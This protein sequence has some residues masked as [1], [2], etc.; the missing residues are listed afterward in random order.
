MIRT[1]GRYLD[2]SLAVN[3]LM[4]GAMIACASRSWAVDTE[5]KHTALEMLLRLSAE[6]R[7]SRYAL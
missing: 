4:V 2:N 3:P 6:I 1:L 5:E 7:L